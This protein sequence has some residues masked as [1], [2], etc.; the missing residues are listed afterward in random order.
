MQFKPLLFEACHS[1]TLVQLQILIA[2]SIVNVV[3]FSRLLFFVSLFT[4]FIIN[5][6]YTP[7]FHGTFTYYSIYIY[8]CTTMQVVSEVTDRIHHMITIAISG[9]RSIYNIKPQNIKNNIHQ[10]G[11]YYFLLPSWIYSISRCQN[12]VLRCQYQ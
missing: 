6:F 1:P 9:L 7:R 4:G 11:R 3:K 8:V 10:E 2:F 5:D 12:Y